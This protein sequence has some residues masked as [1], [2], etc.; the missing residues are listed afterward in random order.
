MENNINK[1]TR[2]KQG[3]YYIIKTKTLAGTLE[4]ITGQRPYIFKDRDDETKIIYSFIYNDDFKEA[5]NIL[6]Q[7]RN[8]F[9]KESE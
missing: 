2:K 6:Y 7:A 1:E 5:L 4:W 3:K 8:K 9:R